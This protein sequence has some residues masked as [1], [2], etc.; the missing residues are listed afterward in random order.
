[1]PS[2]GLVVSNIVSRCQTNGAQSNFIG[3]FVRCRL[4][5]MDYILKRKYM[6]LLTAEPSRLSNSIDFLKK[7][8]TDCKFLLGKAENIDQN[9]N[10]MT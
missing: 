9:K 7:K 2:R 1:M 4:D 8:R 10:F 6:L 3:C 5:G